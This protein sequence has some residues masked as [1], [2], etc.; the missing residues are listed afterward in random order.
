MS[1]RKLWR[2]VFIYGGFFLLCFA[3]LFALA[4]AFMSIFAGITL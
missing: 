4:I 2:G 1:T 3:L